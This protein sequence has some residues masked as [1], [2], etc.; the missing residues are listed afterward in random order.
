[1]TDPTP[2]REVGRPRIFPEEAIFA[3]VFLV[4][5]RDGYGDLTL[6]RVAQEVGCTRQALVRRFGS[7]REMVLAAFVDSAR[8]LPEDL[9]Q[10]R[11]IW[12]SPLEALRARLTDTPSSR[13]AEHVD[14]RTQANLLAF[15]VTTTNWPAYS[16]LFA[17]RLETEARAIEHLLQEA[18]AQ[19]KLTTTDPT[20]LAQ[21][22]LAAWVGNALHASLNDAM[23]QDIPLSQVFDQ[24]I[25]PYR[26]SAD[27]A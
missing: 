3:A 20:T 23:V 18:V 6:E 27:F 15:M 21:V 25:A 22:L 13:T 2:R 10:E 12:D 19:D 14:G 7:K 1:M 24:I 11:P 4:I 5:G 26:R 8:Q 16:G 9:D 17:K